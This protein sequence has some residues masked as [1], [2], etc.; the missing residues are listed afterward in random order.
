MPKP[1]KA[2]NVL[3]TG[4][5][6]TEYAAIITDVHEAGAERDYDDDDERQ[7]FV[8]LATFG[9][10]SLYFQNNVEFSKTGQ[11]CTWRWPPR[12]DAPAS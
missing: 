8:D 4:S 3:F 11:E 1:T 6:G 5:D 9:P 12:V 10:H 2:R 7:Y